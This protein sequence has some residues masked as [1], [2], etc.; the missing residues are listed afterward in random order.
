MYGELR[1]NKSN[2][3]Y[4]SIILATIIGAILGLVAKL[5]DVPEITSVLPIFDDLFGRF[6]IWI[7]A[8]SILSI[9]SNTPINAAIKVFSFFVSMLIVYYTYTILFLGFFPKTQI[10]LW[11]SIS[12]ISPMCAA[13]MW[14]AKETKRI[15]NIL[16]ALPIVVMCTEWYITGS[17]NTLLLVIYL[18]MIVCLLIC[19]PQKVKRSLP[20]IVIAAVTTI[21][22][23]KTGWMELIYGRLLN[24]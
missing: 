19:V 20:I 17:E 13:V 8:A 11:S 12:L 1:N 23:I 5:V 3:E 24:V 2:L 9:F 4:R 15:A 21:L 10:I 6:G 22:L 18:C 16:A 7:F 14:H